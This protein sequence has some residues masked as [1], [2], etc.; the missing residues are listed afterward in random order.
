LGVT[1]VA[2]DEGRILGFESDARPAPI[3][4]FLAIRAIREAVGARER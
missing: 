2:V 4:M 3:P 1:Y